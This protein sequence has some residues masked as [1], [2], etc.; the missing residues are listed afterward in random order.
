MHGSTYRLTITALFVA[1]VVLLGMTPLGLIPL[2]VINLTILHIPVIVGTILLGLKTGLILGFCFGL[3][4]FL[5]LLGMTGAAQSMLAYTLFTA[6]PLYAILMT[7]V[8][9]LLVP[10]TTHLVYRLFTRTDKYKIPAAAPAALIGSLTNTVFYLGLMYMFYSMAGLDL[11]G[12]ADSLGW[13][14]L[15]LLG[16]IGTIAAGGGGAEAFAAAVIAP[17]IVAAVQKM[18]K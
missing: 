18:K 2:G 12:L 5:S 15:S 14:G 16:I 8:P 6:N 9:R 11:V 1:L 7:F 3:V 10:V 13:A 17:P 4:S